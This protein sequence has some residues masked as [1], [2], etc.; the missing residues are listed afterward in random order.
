M[1][2]Y[3]ILTGKLLFVGDFQIIN[4]QAPDLS[5]EFSEYND[6]FKK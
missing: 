2:F 5:N 3:Q 4:F 1:T 6:A